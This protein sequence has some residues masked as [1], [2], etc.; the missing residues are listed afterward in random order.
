MT[1]SRRMPRT[2]VRACY[3]L[4]RNGVLS[5]LIWVLPGQTWRRSCQQKGH[6]PPQPCLSV[7]P[8]SVLISY[9]LP[10]LAKWKLT[11]QNLFLF[12]SSGSKRCN[13][14]SYQL[15]QS[16]SQFP[17][18]DKNAL[19]CKD[20]QMREKRNWRR[21]SSSKKDARQSQC[22]PMKQSFYGKYNI[23]GKCWVCVANDCW[24]NLASMKAEKA[25]R[26]KEEKSGKITWTPQPTFEWCHSL[27]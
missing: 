2:A 3:P 16:L 12:P 24:E 5:L 25:I 14:N 7:T 15:W 27:Y 19:F 22:L 26:T 17:T 6:F 23:T 4:D 1:A 21:F 11:N 18:W 20:E 9:Q 10:S 8:S 13:M